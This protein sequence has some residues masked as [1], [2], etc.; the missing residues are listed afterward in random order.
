MDPRYSRQVVL[1]EIGHEGQKKLC[2]SSV[3]VVGCGALGCT[4]AELLV[5]AGV[6][7]VRIV[8]RDVVELGNLHRQLL[9][10][11][12]DVDACLPKAEAARRKLQRINSTVTIDARIVDVA[13]QNV[14]PLIDG[15]NLVVDGTDNIETRYLLN[16]ACL[17][18]DIPW[19]YGGAVGT[20]G[21]IMNILPGVGPCLRCVFPEPPPP[22][23]LPTC[24]TQGVLNTLTTTVASQ[25]VSEAIKILTGSPMVSR[26]LVTIDPWYSK[27]ISIEIQRIPECPACGHGKRDFLDGLELTEITRLCGR[28]AVQ[29]DPA[30]D[31]GVSLEALRDKLTSLG[32]VEFNGHLVRFWVDDYEVLVFADARAIVRGTTDPVIAK[33]IYA[34]YIGA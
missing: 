3:L 5:R 27:H 34:R 13:P 17:E 8:D 16:D 2:A 25:Q 19:V 1:G 31:L 24:E 30:Q 12:D 7:L 23:S 9:F 32:K 15:V 28:N 18:R 4:A 11:E 6:G 10:D 33:R 14:L 29:I 26:Q 20:T 21:M 22:G